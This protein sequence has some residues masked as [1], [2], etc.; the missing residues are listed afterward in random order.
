MS[1]RRTILLSL[2]VALP[3]FVLAAVGVSHPVSL[4]PETATYWRN[5]HIAILLVF[6]LLGFAPW[7]VVRGRATW[8]S[9][10]VGILGFVYAGLYSALDI[11]AGIGAGALVQAGVPE[12]TATVFTFGDGLGRIGSIAFV[13]ACGFAAAYALLWGG[14]RTLPGGALVI[15]GS[16][17]FLL[18]HIFFPVGVIGQL[19]LAAG[20]VIIV[21]VLAAREKAAAPVAAEVHV[22]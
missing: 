3:P 18:R 10:T 14:V 9:W 8:L 7:L 2:A 6:P 15:V 21:V 20:W 13:G 16:L 19:C 17:L 11:L 4:N 5:L 12:G 1:E 22:V